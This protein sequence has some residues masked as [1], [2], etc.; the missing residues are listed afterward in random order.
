MLV[1]LRQAFIGRVFRDDGNAAIRAFAGGQRRQQ[2]AVVIAIRRGLDDDAACDAAFGMQG[3]QCRE[4][5]FVGH[6][7]GA[8]GKRVFVPG[9]KDMRMAIPEFTGQGHGWARF[10]LRWRRFL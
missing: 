3:F 9:A 8:L 4:G 6:I 1:H 10:S 7:G 5:G 2:G